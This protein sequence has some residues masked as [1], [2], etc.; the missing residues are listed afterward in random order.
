MY[1]WREKFIL[2]CCLY[3]ELFVKKLSV[4]LLV[5]VSIVLLIGLLFG[6]TSS[7]GFRNVFIDLYPRVE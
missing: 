7:S 4:Y 3:N 1:I 5:L 2:S 6:K